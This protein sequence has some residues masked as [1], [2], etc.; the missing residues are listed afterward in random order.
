MKL[1]DLR[2]MNS[3]ER[4]DALWDYMIGKIKQDDVESISLMIGQLR[5]PERASKVAKAIA[6]NFD[7]MS[8][9]EFSQWWLNGGAYQ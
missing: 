4:E 5:K 3:I 6:E 9:A 7:N 8:A 2:A 1:Q